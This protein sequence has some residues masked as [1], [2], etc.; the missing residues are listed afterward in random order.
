MATAAE[1][2]QPDWQDLIREAIS[3]EEVMRMLRDLVAQREQLVAH[4]A[5]ASSA[6]GRNLAVQ[7]GSDEFVA[8]VI[9]RAGQQGVQVSEDDVRSWLQANGLSWSSLAAA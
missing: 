9:E 1:L 8:Q 7:P 5:R 6:R 4:V 3:D 2:F